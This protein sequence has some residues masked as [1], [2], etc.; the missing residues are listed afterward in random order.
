MELT[1]SSAGASRM[2]E[3]RLLT[4]PM[5]ARKGN[6][7]VDIGVRVLSLAAGV[8]VDEFASHASPTNRPNYVGALIRTLPPRVSGARHFICAKESGGRLYLLD[9]PGR[10]SSFT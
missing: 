7:E 8:L 6:W 1:K 10:G 9:S 2:R 3:C 5:G 4:T